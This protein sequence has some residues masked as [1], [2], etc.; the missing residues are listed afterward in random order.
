M[1]GEENMKT[2]DTVDGSRRQAQQILIA[3]V[4]LAETP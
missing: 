1:N 4:A 3:S 2:Q